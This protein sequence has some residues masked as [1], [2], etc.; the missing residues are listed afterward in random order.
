MKYEEPLPVNRHNAIAMLESGVPEQIQGAII[1]LALSDP[2][3]D[4]VVAQALELLKSNVGS[5]RA[6]AATAIGH[7]ARIHG[8]IDKDSVLP[9]LR[10]LAGDPEA[11]GRAEDALDDIEIFTN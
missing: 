2:D 5:V 7:V 10:A 6:T 11:A 1:Q 9:A 8:S 3:G 4:W